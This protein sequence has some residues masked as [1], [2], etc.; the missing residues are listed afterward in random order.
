[1]GVF[2]GFSGDFLVISVFLV[3]RICFVSLF[4]MAIPMILGLFSGIVVFFFSKFRCFHLA[5]FVQ[6]F[7]GNTVCQGSKS[8]ER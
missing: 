2:E 4:A 7:F 3:L 6:V 8:R 1:M 5:F